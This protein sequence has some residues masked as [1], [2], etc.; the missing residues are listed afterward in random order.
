MLI[1]PPAGEARQ[2]ADDL[3]RVGV[4]DVRAV[5]VDLN[6]RRVLVVEGVA[7]HVR[8]LVDDQHLLARA[9]RQALGQDRAGEARA[10]HQVVERFGAA[11]R[12]DSRR[13]RGRPDPGGL[14]SGLGLVLLR[15]AFV[16]GHGTI[17][18][19]RD[20]LQTSGD[21]DWTG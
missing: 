12:A 15:V 18:P 7:G 17:V 14:L 20:V 2:V 4:E 6:P 21:A 16:F 3:L 8:A 19:A 5:P 10:H 9:G 11:G 1:G 13:R